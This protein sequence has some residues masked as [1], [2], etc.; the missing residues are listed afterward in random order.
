MGGTWA[1]PDW[2][3][4]SCLAVLTPP[5]LTLPLKGGGNKKVGVALRGG[6]YFPVAASNCFFNSATRCRR[7]ATWA[8]TSGSRAAAGMSPTARRIPSVPEPA[9]RIRKK[10]E[11]NRGRLLRGPFRALDVLLQRDLGVEPVPLG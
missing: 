10:V 4:R 6:G 1:S 3:R 8:A 9:A 11:K 2:G 7:S 5:T